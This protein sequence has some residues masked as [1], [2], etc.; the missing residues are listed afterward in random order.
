M[1]LQTFI[2]PLRFGWDLVPMGLAGEA[3]GNLEDA[4]SVG[5]SL[6]L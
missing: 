1:P 5:S 2:L 3:K 6:E 4:A